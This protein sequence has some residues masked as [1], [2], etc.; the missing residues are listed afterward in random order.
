M[1][2][3]LYKFAFLTLLTAT[4]C[5]N[6]ETDV[7]A[8]YRNADGS[9][10]YVNEEASQEFEWTES[11]MDEG[12]PPDEYLIQQPDLKVEGFLISG[13]LLDRTFTCEDTGEAAELTYFFASNPPNGTTG[14]WIQRFAAVCGEKY[15]VVQYDD[16]TPE[17]IFGPFTKKNNAQ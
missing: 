5:G 13:P 2:K 4:S 3:K 15:L 1:F 14:G 8:E 10:E 9:L 6:A 11:A 7:F 16:P 12:L 17:R